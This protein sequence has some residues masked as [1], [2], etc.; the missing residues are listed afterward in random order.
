MTDPRPT[1]R[2][3]AAQRKL[4]YDQAAS[5]AADVNGTLR[6]S[7]RVAWIVA[8]LA[9]AVAGLEALAL[10]AL[11]PLKTVVPYTI[12]VDRH[13]GYV[14]T[15]QPLAP[16]ALSQNVA[17]TQSF[18]VQ[19]VLARETFDATDLRE[20]YQKVMLWSAGDA[21]AGFQRQYDRTNPDSPL[22][23][24]TPTTVVSVGIESVSQLTAS[25]AL[26]RFST[27]RH[28]AGA[29]GGEQ[30]SYAAV[31]A[32]RYTGAPMRM[33]DRFQN[34]LGFQVTRYRRDSETAP[35]MAAPPG[36]MTP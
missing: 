11:T 5:W 12:L 22:K 1:S 19:Y 33:E 17:V 14:E 27:T 34:P 26:V 7:R 29:P 8:A 18:I 32:Y 28:E 6:A 16:G 9:C 24:Y 13:T 4:H 23:L 31:L 20:N 2:P 10:A 15:A 36:A 25:T 21:R 35:G 3:G 30:R